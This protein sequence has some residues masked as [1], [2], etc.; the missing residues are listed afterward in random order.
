MAEATSLQELMRLSLQELS[1]VY[2][3]AG[4]EDY[5]K[6]ECIRW[7]RELAR[8]E[9]DSDLGF[10][11]IRAADSSPQSLYEQCLSL[12]LMAERQIIFCDEADQWTQDKQLLQYLEEPESQTILFLSI[13]DKRK[14]TKALKQTGS[15]VSLDPVDRKAIAPW[16]EQRLAREQV[17]IDRPAL[18]LLAQRY[19]GELMGFDH[20]IAKLITYVGAAARIG[21]ADVG[22]VLFSVSESNVFEL[23]ELINQKNKV[24][25]L[26]KLDQMMKSGSSAPELVA[27]L[28]WH[29]KRLWSIWQLQNQQRAA[30]Q[31][32]QA[33]NLKDWAYQKLLPQMRLFNAK[34]FA[35]IF[36]LFYRLEKD[37]RDSA[38]S[39]QVILEKTL[40]EII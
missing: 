10:S 32:M 40:L 19:Q 38:V 25:M 14:I 20:E 8:G 15:L 35:L 17:K 3:L 6:Q 26:L 16:I 29:F 39:P 18:A 4:R 28:L 33:L 7:A 13:T 23:I 24:G 36:Q 9:A 5:L 22:A 2:I 11:L 30:A 31:I 1:P 21:V 12:P 27:V 34:R 37:L